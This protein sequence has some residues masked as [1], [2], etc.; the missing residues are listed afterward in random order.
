MT[1]ELSSGK[2]AQELFRLASLVQR[3][4]PLVQPGP[5][6]ITSQPGDIGGRAT[7]TMQ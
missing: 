6:G 2:R 3:G 7:L 1:C 4:F 5:L